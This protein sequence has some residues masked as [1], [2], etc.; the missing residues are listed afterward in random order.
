M[1]KRPSAI[2]I[3]RLTSPLTWHLAGFA[4]MFVLVVVLSVRFGMDWA[5]TNGRSTDALA[6]KQVELKAQEMQTAPLRGLDKRVE[7]SRAQIHAFYEKR[8]PPNY[9]SIASR[10]G[11]LQVNSGARLTRVQ[12]TQGPPGA[13]LTEISMDAGISGG[14]PQ[15]M[16]FVNSLERD[17]TFFVIRAMAS[18]RS[19]GRIGEPA[20]A[21][22]H[23]AAGR[24][25]RPP[26][27]CRPR[28]SPTT[29]RLPQ[30]QTE[31][32]AISHGP[33]HGNGKQAPGHHCLRTLCH[34]HR[35]RRLGDSLAPPEALPR[36]GP[37]RRK[38]QEAQ[39]PCGRGNAGRNR[40]REFCRSGRGKADQRRS[41]PHGAL[42]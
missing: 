37:F 20:A 4:V 11:E 15:I 23:L 13:D 3:E 2:W 29:L 42:R 14:Y 8:I 24:P 26:A 28:R 39:R 16:R 19:A 1:I 10:I 33:S 36:P 12:Y 7:Q 17:Q 18:D 5:A 21:R 27:D 9:S 30:L 38:L 32:R 34:H 6:S 35:H 25:M 41:R 40:R 22:L 31:W